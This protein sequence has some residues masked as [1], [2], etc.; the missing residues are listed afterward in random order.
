M[1]FIIYIP[2]GAIGE[3]LGRLY[4]IEEKYNKLTSKPPAA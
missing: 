4:E 3:E 2:I 1:G